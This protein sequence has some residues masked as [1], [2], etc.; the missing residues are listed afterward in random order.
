MFGVLYEKILQHA[1]GS[2]RTMLK[3]DLPHATASN[4]VIL[5]NPSILER[6]NPVLYASVAPYT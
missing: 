1:L 4:W 2:R 6:Y 3:V 5:F